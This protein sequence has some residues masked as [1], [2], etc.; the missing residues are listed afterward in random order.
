MISLF[1]GILITVE[2]VLLSST[3]T[4]KKAIVRLLSYVISI[5]LLAHSAIRIP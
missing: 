1:P 4:H 3:G 2:V 5:P